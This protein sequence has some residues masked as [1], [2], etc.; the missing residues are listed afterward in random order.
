MAAAVRALPPGAVRRRPSSATAALLATLVVALLL[1]FGISAFW[2]STAVFILIGAIGALGLNVLTG[3]TGQVSLGHAFFLGIGAYT[4]AVLGGDHHVNAAIWIPMAGVVAGLAGAIIGP[5]AL[6]LRG[7]YLAIVTIG[8]V[9]I[10]GHIFN[11][12]TSVTGGSEGRAV[13]APQFGDADFRF[14]NYTFAGLAF[15]RNGLYYYLC[16]LI[17]CVSMLYVRNLMRTRPGR[18]LQAVRDREVAAALMGVDLARSKV[19]AFVI[20]S[21]LAGVCGALYGSFL[22]HVDPSQ[23]G[24]LLSIQFVA[25]IIVGGVGT[26]SGALLGSIFVTGLPT[27][28]QH[29]SDSVPFLQHTAGGSGIAVGDATNISYGVLIILFLVLEP[30]GL[31][32]LAARVSLLIGR[33]RGAAAPIPP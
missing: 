2:L 20:S 29:Y 12:W 4:A 21:F 19:G 13:P 7:L 22:R 14:D 17:L 18:A 32:G 15:D 23:W 31:V 28:L 30:R 27:V 26:V 33:R 10:G 11:V 24:L 5:T 6:R 8:L 16:L 9:F 25:I 1:P 3:Y